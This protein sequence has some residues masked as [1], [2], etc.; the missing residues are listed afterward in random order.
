MQKLTI[1]DSTNIAG[2]GFLVETDDIKDDP[3]C[4]AKI[5]R[6]IMSGYKKP[7]V[8]NAAQFANDMQNLE[9]DDFGF[10]T[11]GPMEMF[12]RPSRGSSKNTHDDLDK[13]LQD[14]ESNNDSD[15]EYE[16][17]SDD[18]SVESM[19]GG[20]PDMNGMESTLM[21]SIG[22]GSMRGMNGI[23]PMGN[24]SLRQPHTQLQSMTNEQKRQNI[25]NNAFSDTE[26]NSST[27][28]TI[29][30]ER[31]GEDKA[32]KL[33]EIN[34]LIDILEEEG[35]RLDRIPKVTMI[36]SLEEIDAVLKHLLLKND[37]KRY[38][39]FAEE[40]IIGG[41]HAIEWAFDGKRSYLGHKPDMTDWH[42]TV[43]GKLRRM[44]HDTSTVVGNIM[45]QYGLGS[46][47]RI[48]LELI[49]SA[50]LYSRLRSSQRNDTIIDDA[51]FNA[52]I[53]NIMDNSS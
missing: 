4:A 14:L 35:E 50:F 24:S 8:N 17:D 44:R 1:T 16:T 49:P 40:I 47:S 20:G 6:E 48:L 41:S 51:E 18:D 25:I 3:N 21:G 11:M 31:R 7:D 2:M 46:K 5:E 36:N 34:H 19:L 12:K 39:T 37:R 22:V 27:I 53:N 33:E 13:L 32:R 45:G 23:D 28:V 42:K 43:Q 15:S 29:E 30:K 10:Q 52:G 9:N 26:M 38:G